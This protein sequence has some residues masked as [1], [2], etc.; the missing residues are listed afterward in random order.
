MDPP[1]LVTLAARRANL[2]PFKEYQKLPEAAQEAIFNHHCY[3]DITWQIDVYYEEPIPIIN[4]IL[5]YNI[6]DFEVGRFVKDISFEEAEQWRRGLA[7][8]RDG[9]GFRE[10]FQDLSEILYETNADICHLILQSFV[11][12]TWMNLVIP[13]HTM[14][15]L[16]QEIVAAFDG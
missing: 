10:S 14:L 12:N 1:S 15:S 7:L 11:F 6:Q 9:S 4:L 13:R 3:P 2:I 5:F 8:L 16:L